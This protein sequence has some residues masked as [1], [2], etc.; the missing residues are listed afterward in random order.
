ME[1]RLKKVFRNYSSL[2]LIAS[3]IILADQ[4]TKAVIR[5]NLALQETWMPLTWLAPY[6]RIVHWYNTGVAFGMFQNGNLIFAIIATIVSVAIFIFY[7]RIPREE[8]ILR[9]ATSMML[10]GAV[11]NLIDRITVGHVTD[12]ISLGSFAVFN[13]ADMSITFGVCILVL[14]VWLQE[15]RERKQLA[16]ENPPSPSKDEGNIS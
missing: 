1:E 10:A 5:Q 12:F 8:R 14:G 4:V 6:A 3:V 2:I 7:P 9:I 15:R 16:L 13:I 11:G